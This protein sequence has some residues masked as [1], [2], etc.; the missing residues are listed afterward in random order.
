ML[1][2]TFILFLFSSSLFS[3]KIDNLSSFRDIDSDSYFRFNYENDYFA[4]TDENYT[5]GYSFE[6][7]LPAFKTNPLN[8]LLFIPIKS[9]T[10][11]GLAIEHIGYTPNHYERSEIQ[12]GDR[13]FAAGILL[14]SFAVAT[15]SVRKSR[16]VSSLSLGLL[17]PGLLAKNCK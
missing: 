7:V 13:P 5:Q 15:D 14:K 1:K 4:A 3:Q 6:L 2:F 11:Y 9:T 16:L 12:R 10:K 8:H 17:G